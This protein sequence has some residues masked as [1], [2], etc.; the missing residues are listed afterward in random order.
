[1]AKEYSVVQYFPNE[2]YE[3]VKRFVEAEEAVP[4]AIACA[5]SLGAR[6]GT[7]TRVIITDGW[8]YTSWEWTFEDGIT[9][10]TTLELIGKLKHGK[11][12]T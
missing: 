10:G 12:E 2:T 5:T 11:K 6:L 1:M 8:D 7:T 3:Y 4:C 9:F